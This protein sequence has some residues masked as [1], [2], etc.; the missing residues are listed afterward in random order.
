MIKQKFVEVNGKV[1][2]TP[3]QHVDPETDEV[4]VGGEL[5]DYQEYVY[6]MLNKP[7][8]VISATEDE[9]H[10]TVIDLLEPADLVQEP[11]PVGRLD[12][13]TEGLLLLTND[14]KLTH[15][16]I[17]PNHHVDKCY[18][19][20]I[21]G[22]VTEEDIA[23]FKEGVRIENDYQTMPARLTI[24]SINEDEQLS[25][26]EVTIQEGKFHQVKQMFEAVEK[27]VLY[28]K[29]LSMGSLTLDPK[30]ELGK[31]RELTKEEIDELKGN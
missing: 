10:M 29:R 3:K 13:D 27:E 4:T 28:L 30:L 16:L 6:F 2:K 9:R 1:V 15:Q 31:Y 5:L 26:V 25:Q 17:S 22:L 23:A 14:G 19:A 11:H 12:I 8:G 20:E 7:A 18:F 24:R 21:D